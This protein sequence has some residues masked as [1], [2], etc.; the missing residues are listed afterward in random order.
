MP[1]G[2]NET[3][4]FIRASV[5]IET[6]ATFFF[7]HLL[8]TFFA[9]GQTRRVQLFVCADRAP[10]A[11]E[12]PMRW[13]IPRMAFCAL[14]IIAPAAILVSFAKA[15]PTFFGDNSLQPFEAIP[16]CQLLPRQFG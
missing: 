10:N 8:E 16:L 3:V 9:L 1:I 12:Y 5:F 7:D 2:A 6:N 13:R 11:L 15:F 4:S 14:K